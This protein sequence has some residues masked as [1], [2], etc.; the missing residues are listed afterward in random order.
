MS[1]LRQPVRAF[2]LLEL[3]VVLAMFGLLLGLVAGSMGSSAVGGR[4]RT[5]L[6]QLHSVLASQRVLAMDTG[7]AQR[8]VLRLPPAVDARDEATRHFELLIGEADD[9][10]FELSYEELEAWA[11]DAA[12]AEAEGEPID[13]PGIVFRRVDDAQLILMNEREE[14]V[15]SLSVRFDRRGRA[16]ARLWSFLNRRDSAAGASGRGGNGIV[17]AFGFDPLSGSVRPWGPDEAEDWYAA[18]WREAR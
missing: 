4:Q 8:V 5:T 15:E 13:G 3:L 2:T 9:P 10:A 7:A 6:A 18:A 14:L 16:D 12:R 1:R 17:G 11:D